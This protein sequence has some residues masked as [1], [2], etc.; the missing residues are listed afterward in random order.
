MSAQRL[1]ETVAAGQE[2]S[3]Q[4][5]FVCLRGFEHLIGRSRSRVSSHR[6]HEA[7]A[8]EIALR[9]ARDLVRGCPLV[10]SVAL[11][12]S[13]ASGGYGPRD[14][15]DFDLIVKPG[16]KYTSYLVAHL[17]GLKC[18][19]RYRH[20]V[21]DESHHTPLL[22]K[23]ACINVV[24]TEDQMRPFARRD[25]NM[26]FE[27][28]RCIPFFGIGTFQHALRENA[29]VGE[30][31]PQVFER[32]WPEDAPTSPSLF[33]RVVGWIESNPRMLRLVER[34]SRRIAWR[35]YRGV[36]ASRSRSPAAVA[37]MDFLRRAKY[38]YEVFQD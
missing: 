18:G 11:S 19:W 38:P 14:D 9:Y 24:W 25:E 12:G 7:E 15:I 4:D 37:R 2:W 20:R 5:G 30:F 17:V 28:M 26:A 8:Q 31:F 1:R 21:L 3:L 34:A 13:L 16:T 27:L 33:G 6:E 32:V 22:P 35:L 23:I 29:W 10:T 36:Q